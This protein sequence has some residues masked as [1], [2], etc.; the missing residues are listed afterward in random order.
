M[1]T[2]H[3]PMHVQMARTRQKRCSCGKAADFLC[4]FIT[5]TNAK[6]TCSDGICAKCK[7]TVDGKDY[8]W[9]HSKG[10]QIVPA[11]GRLPL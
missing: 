11:Q 3:G 7:T 10:Q 5:T 2:P 6:K 4:D 9:R 1:N 8:C